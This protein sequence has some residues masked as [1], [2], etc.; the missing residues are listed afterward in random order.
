MYVYI[1]IFKYACTLYVYICFSYSPYLSVGFLRLQ[2][3]VEESI[4]SY[5]AKKAE[6]T[7][8]NINLS[9]RVHTFKCYV[10]TNVHAIL[11]DEW[12]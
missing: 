2:R 9:M 5:F 6:K 11:V 10:Y 12:S 4:I 7:V 3:V 1:E 8:P